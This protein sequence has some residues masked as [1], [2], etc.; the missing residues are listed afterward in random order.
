[1]RSVQ[2]VNRGVPPL[3]RQTEY[4][5]RV[6]GNG[7]HSDVHVTQ[8]WPTGNTRDAAV[9]EARRLGLTGFTDERGKFVS[10][11]F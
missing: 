2:I 5:V 1:M 11:E 6:I 8:G 10:L 3:G 4:A 9:R 7:V